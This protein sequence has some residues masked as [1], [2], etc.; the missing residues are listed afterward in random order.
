MTRTRAL[1]VLLGALLTACGTPSAEPHPSTGA[2]VPLPSVASA[3]SSGAPASSAPAASP[4]AS[5]VPA[6]TLIAF[7]MVPTAGTGGAAE[8][9]DPDQIDRLTGA[10]PEVI[11]AARAAVARNLGPGNRL[12]AFV[13]PGCRNTGA[14]V[15]IQAGR[16]TAALT[17]GEGVACF[18]AEWF[19]A[20]FAVPATLVTPGTRVG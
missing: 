7:A 5:P 8:V 16:I 6:P 15:A 10:P 17:G 2:P 12:F 20:V 4:V 11:G 14:T 18:A 13:L 3:A 1:A 9:T 19:L